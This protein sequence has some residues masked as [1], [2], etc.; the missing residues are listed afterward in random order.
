MKESTTRAQ[1]KALLK[2]IFNVP[3]DAFSSHFSLLCTHLM[4]ALTDFI[5]TTKM[6]AFEVFM[7]LLKHFP[8]LC[9]SRCEIFDQ[10]LLLMSSDR[11]PTNRALLDESIGLVTSVFGKTSEVSLW[12][13]QEVC[14]L[15]V[16]F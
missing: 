15:Q 6:F 10:Y 14:I 8:R 12:N 1:L 5:H 13:P 2:I 7:L 16:Q 9:S 3:T 11:R 4:A